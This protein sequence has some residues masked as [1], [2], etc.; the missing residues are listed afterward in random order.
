MRQIILALAASIAVASPAFADPV[1]DLMARQMARSHIPGAAVAVVQD[2]KVVKLSAYGT[3]NLEWGG[4]TDPDTSFQIASATKLF[5]GIILMRLVERGDLALGDPLTKYFPEAPPAWAGVKVGQLANH[6]SGLPQGFE[7]P[8]PSDLAQALETAMRA[9]L[10]HEPGAKSQYGLTDFVVLLAILE[11]VSGKSYSA[12][13]E[14]E[15]AAPLGL[16]HTRFSQAANKGPVRWSDVLDKRASVYAW[17][18]GEQHVS[19]GLYPQ[20]TYAAGG[21][22][23][24]ARDLAAVFAA[25]DEGKLLKPESLRI[26][27]TPPQLTGGGTGG[28]GVGWTAGVQRGVPI[29]GHSGGPALADVLRVE[30]RKLTV[31][32]LANQHRFYPLLAPAVLDIYLPKGAEPR[33]I[34][35]K[36]PAL[37]AALRQALASAAAGPVDRALFSNEG[38]KEMVPFF[39]ELGPTMLLAVGPVRSLDLLAE[40]SKGGQTTRKYRAVFDDHRMFW[41]LTTDA[42]GQIVR[43]IPTGEANDP[44]RP[45]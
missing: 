10:V 6:T 20:V 44:S 12:L 17:E 36:R 43:L 1:D 41:M 25:L 24:S 23:S 26:L 45:E 31:I 39:D 2:G 16:T 9:P 22:F 7:G 4:K 38:A 19:D 37:T 27:E 3:A 18:G 28:F 40:A 34:A 13:L 29:V 33:A 15:I 42:K 5:T 32:V 21:L 14:Q 30:D 35:D 8:R 11:K